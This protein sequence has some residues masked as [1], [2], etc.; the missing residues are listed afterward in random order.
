MIVLRW[1]LGRVFHAK[2]REM[3]RHA[4]ANRHPLAQPS[5]EELAQT[6]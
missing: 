1:I 5:A 2:P 6:R 3:S 4:R